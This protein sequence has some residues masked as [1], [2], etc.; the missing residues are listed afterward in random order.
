MTDVKPLKI[1]ISSP[2]D[3]RP[4][5]LIA[6]RVVQQLARE[7]T[8]HLRLE[9]VMWEREPLVAS[10]H[11]QTSIAQPRDTDIVIVILW[12]RLGFPLPVE[13]FPGPLSEK[14]VT[15]TEW[16][17]EDAL[18]SSRA[19]KLPDL[20]MYRKKAAVTGSFEDEE[21]VR[22]QLAQKRLV[23]DFFRRWFVDQDA[24]AFTAAF[25]EFT[26]ISDFET[27][28]E[29]HLRELLRRR[30]AET[31]GDLPAPIKWHRGSP[32][33]GLLSF[34]PVHAPVFFGRMRA[35]NEIREQLCSQIERGTAFL[36]VSGASGSGKS[37][38]IKA[39]VLPDLGLRG[40]IGNVAL[41][42]HAVFRPS[43]G[44]GDLL[45]RLATAILSPGALP[46]LTSLSC[47]VETLTHLLRDAPAQARLPI[48]QGLTHASKAAALT[49]IA[50]ARLLIVVDQLEEIFT[51][52]SVRQA[53]R[54]AFASALDSLAR[55]G[56]VWVIAT[57][58][59][60]FHGSLE[61]TPKL[62]A[63]SSK[64]GRYDLLPPDPTEMAQIVRQPAREAGLSFEVDG[65]RGAH[66]DD[67]I[68]KAAAQSPGSLPLL[69]FLLDQLW[70]RRST[71]GAL[72]FS[73]YHELDGLEGALA[74]RAEEIF[75][76]QPP[77]VQA[78]LP[79]VLRE[80]VTVSDDT[81]QTATSRPAPMSQFRPG[82]PE[83]ALIEAFIDPQA[84]LLVVDGTTE[85]G[86]TADHRGVAQVR[87]AHEA[88][89]THWPRA[90]DQ[91]DADRRDL[92][93]LGR[94]ARGATRWKAADR[95]HRDSLA[96]ARGLPLTEARDLERRW[97]RDVPVH[98]AEY[99]GASL[100]LARRRSIRLGVMLAG[101]VVSLPV[102]AGIVWIAMVWHGV[103]QV[104]QSMDFVPIAADCFRM[105]TPP[106]E[107]GRF[108]HEAQRD[109]CVAQFEIGKLAVTQA[110]WRLVMVENPDPARFKGDRN[111]VEM[112]S[113]DDARAFAR[114][115]SW[116]G[117]RNYRLPTEAEWEYAARGRTTTTWFWGNKL[118]DG[119]AY[120]NLRDLTYQSKYF[121][122]DEAII[123][124]HDGNDVTA[125][126]GSYKPNPL[127]LYDMTG[128]VF[129]WIE[130]CFGDYAQ[131]PKDGR[132]ADEANCKSRVVRGGSWTSRPR[133][134]R[135]GSRDTYPP[136]NRNDVVGFRLAR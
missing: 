64:D 8:Y 19:R 26:D 21:L 50:E 126:V 105:G 90:R 24:E 28:L 80:L 108:P 58:R 5:R 66:L 110:Q 85:A 53:E 54:E 45:T 70:Q 125:P 59:S 4:E 109:V 33:R 71:A 2:S 56:L 46:E 103:R 47:D 72:T 22:Q 10:E 136:T 128:N 93:L 123:G 37:S 67:V 124:C 96:L 43:E 84:R 130:D 121:N 100:W 122:V 75:G 82:T 34:E 76:A 97:S 77:E 118:E 57:M 40:M 112:V 14:A 78:A 83:L 38:F 132:A 31:E 129:Q 117:S 127:G 36:L 119:C 49:D 101:A 98:I 23:D 68:L 6:E 42:R 55:C 62:L 61:G 65:T 25:R 94:L 60:D 133:F 87:V 30:V 15:G 92:E 69:S 104:E 11:F 9:A 63:L 29:T 99:I 106:D 91:I 12:S 111:P 113:W 16:E 35:R 1:F 20:L 7:F 74:L 52:G 131:A 13:K 114:R 95:K 88:L 48:R 27:L 79:K 73:A 116:F 3:V 51:L 17:F 89:L 44:D 39:G 120:A 134:T 135:S 115:M 32:Y 107:A 18:K 102:I 81:R 41:V 86:G